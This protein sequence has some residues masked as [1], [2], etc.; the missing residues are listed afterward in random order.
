MENDRLNA[1]LWPA[2]GLPS[3]DGERYFAASIEYLPGHPPDPF[4]PG[5]VIPGRGSRRP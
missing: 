2:T 5:S 3:H 1:L 4:R